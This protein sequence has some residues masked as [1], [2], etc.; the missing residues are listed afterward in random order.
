VV[1]GQSISVNIA[2]D[3]SAPPSPVRRADV[4]MTFIVEPD[5]LC[6]GG[7]GYLDPT[8]G[9][10]ED[11]SYPGPGKRY[12]D[13][14]PNVLIRP[15]GNILSRDVTGNAIFTLTVSVDVMG[16]DCIVTDYTTSGCVGKLQLCNDLDND[17]DGDGVP[18]GQDNCPNI[19]NPDQADSDGDGVG[20]ACDNCPDTPNPDQA[21]ADS[22]GIGD[23][24]DPDDDNDGYDDGDDCAPLDPSINPGATEVC[25]GVDNDCDGLVDE[26]LSTDNDGDG[27]YTPGSCLTPNDDCDDSDNTVYPGAPELCDGKDNDCDGQTDEGLSTDSDGDGHYTPGSCLTPNDDCDD[28]DNTVYPGA[29][30]L[31]DG[32]DNDCDG[33][34]D[35]GTVCDDLYEDNDDFSTAAEIGMGTIDD[36]IC[37]DDDW[38]YV[39]VGSGNY[40][41][42]T[43]TF[44]HDDG[45][46]D[47]YLYY[48]SSEI[49]VASSTSSTDD[50]LIHYVEPTDGIYYIK[51]VNFEGYAGGP[52][53]YDITISVL[54]T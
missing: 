9:L 6:C 34:I 42:V 2:N 19:P 26:G 47:L 37:I 45:D 12:I 10:T 23:A 20:D 32:K 16:E 28:S 50:E 30:E 53:A 22:D 15:A 3:C 48:D 33:Q 24:C 39:T 27:H 4:T 29:P 11:T 18:D 38:Y 13:Y 14:R 44:T 40:L 35:E 54:V 41:E 46:L 7:S 8:G 21:D 49:P 31:C 52:T 36:L 17:I 5:A 1:V 43:I 51:V 25:D